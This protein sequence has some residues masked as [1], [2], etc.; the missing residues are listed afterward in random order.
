PFACVSAFPKAFT[1]PAPAFARQ[2]RSTGFSFWAALT[3]HATLATVFFA[4][5]FILAERHLAAGVG[6]AT[7]GPATSP[8]TAR[9][10]RV[11]DGACAMAR[12]RRQRVFRV[13]PG[14]FRAAAGLGA[15]EGDAQSQA[16]RDV[17]SGRPRRHGPSVQLGV[18]LRNMG[19]A[20]TP[21]TVLAA[22]RA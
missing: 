1:K 18:L 3:S 8:N 5:A 15:A 20:S 12:A 14:R 13:N 7:A 19:P 9:P 22:A 2:A 17:D 6:F 4:T 11:G 16:L 10:S 21:E